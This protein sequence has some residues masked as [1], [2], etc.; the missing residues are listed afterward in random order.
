MIKTFEKIEIPLF[1]PNLA[2][3]NFRENQN[4]S[5][6]ANRYHGALPKKPP[7]LR[8]LRG[9]I[10][11]DQLFLFTHLRKAEKKENLALTLRNP[12]LCKALLYG[13]GPKPG[14]RVGE[15][16]EEEKYTRPST[17]EEFVRELA[18]KN[19]LELLPILYGAPAY[20]SLLVHCPASDSD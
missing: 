17:H 8:K 18:R 14:L 20:L 3:R 19:W 13:P 2:L 9:K 6:N 10:A 15:N 1:A 7:W 11:R 16:Q 12:K 4:K 5:S